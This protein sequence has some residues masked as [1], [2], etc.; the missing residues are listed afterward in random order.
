MLAIS[1]IEG[2]GNKAS[3]EYNSLVDQE[4]ELLLK[5]ASLEERNEALVK[6]HSENL[7]NA[8]F[9]NLKKF[10]YLRSNNTHQIKRNIHYITI[11]I[12]II[13]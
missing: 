13:I 10:Q 9:F 1:E 4:R 11:I 7:G 2:A 8:N 6:K 5:L 12:I 3:I